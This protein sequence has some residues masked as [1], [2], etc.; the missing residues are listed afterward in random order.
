[1]DSLCDTGYSSRQPLWNELQYS[2]KHYKS[3]MHLKK[4]KKGSRILTA[5]TAVY[6]NGSEYILSSHPLLISVSINWF[7]LLGQLLRSINDNTTGMLTDELCSSLYLHNTGWSGREVS[8]K[9]S[10]RNFLWN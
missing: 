6:P 2:P 8:G 4:K 10:V 9:I 5:L 1:M 3:L 7:D